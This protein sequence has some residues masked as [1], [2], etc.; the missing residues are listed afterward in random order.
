M[1]VVLCSLDSALSTHTHTRTSSTVRPGPGA[2][3]GCASCVIYGGVLFG[4]GPRWA[5]PLSALSTTFK[6]L[7]FLY[8]FQVQ[9][10]CSWCLMLMRIH[11]SKLCKRFD[12]E[13]SSARF[14][15]L[16]SIPDEHSATEQGSQLGISTC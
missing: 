15:R 7:Y 9:W 10:S 11:G 3:R 6:R 12:A 5:D 16:D 14:K 1:F 4:Q 2:V 13:K 8:P